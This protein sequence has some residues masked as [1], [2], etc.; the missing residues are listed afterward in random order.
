MKKQAQR[1]IKDLRSI[2]WLTKCKYR[3][4]YR[5]QWCILVPRAIRL[6]NASWAEETTG[7]RDVN[8][9]E[10]VNPREV[11]KEEV[12]EVHFSSV[13]GMHTPES[14]PIHLRYT[15]KNNKQNSARTAGTHASLSTSVS[16][17]Q[18]RLR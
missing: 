3:N 17:K 2:D 14:I 6:L 10:R 16:T 7:A 13:I 18:L 4:A 11:F 1:A 15:Y 8:G 9:S 12:G 5:K